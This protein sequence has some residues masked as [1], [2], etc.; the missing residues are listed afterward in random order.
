M[1]AY[2]AGPVEMTTTGVDLLNNTTGW[3]TPAQAYQEIVFTEPRPGV[4]VVRMNRPSTYNAWG[5]GMGDELVAA[6]DR[7]T[8]DERVH[9]LV[10]TGT[11][12]AFSAGGE[13]N[14]IL[15]TYIDSSNAL[16]WAREAAL[17]NLRNT[18][19]VLKDFDKPTIAAVNGVA[20]GA[21]FGM[22]LI[23]DI[24]IASEQARFGN[25]YMRR[26]TVPSMAPYYLPQVVGLN[27]ACRLIFGDE[28]IGAREAERIGLVTRVVPARDLATSVLDLAERIAA[29]PLPA[30][31][32]VKRL[33]RTGQAVDEHT[34]RQMAVLSAAALS[35][36]ERGESQST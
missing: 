4:A 33:L 20:A 31:R 14:T 16:E 23:C 26:G 8:A 28:V 12:R 13:A 35:T 6:M 10:F 1:Y 17:L 3:G 27:H 15:P 2:V 29:Q 34:L 7:V 5:G 36:R 21:A 22:T 9:V 19:Q 30:L 18:L 32:L 24:R 25:I 11:G